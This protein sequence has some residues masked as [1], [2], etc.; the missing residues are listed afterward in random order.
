MQFNNVMPEKCLIIVKAIKLP[1][2]IFEEQVD[3][4]YKF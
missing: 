3:Q 4:N 1:G 2:R